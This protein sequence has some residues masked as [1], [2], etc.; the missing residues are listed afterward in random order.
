MAPEVIIVLILA[1][2]SL[3]LSIR[4]DVVDYFSYITMVLAFI[5]AFIT[6]GIREY[7][8]SITLFVAALIMLF[9]VIMYRK[10]KDH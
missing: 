9:I 2:I 5:L 4:Y 1:S 6:L 10:A 7:T 8:L 3:I